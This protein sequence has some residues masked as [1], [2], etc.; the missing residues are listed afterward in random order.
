MN[1]IGPR[2]R[3]R[4]LCPTLSA[5]A[6]AAMLEGLCESKDDRMVVVAGWK[7]TLDSVGARVSTRTGAD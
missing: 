2:P 5:A 7:A 6:L 3:T 1:L 4:R